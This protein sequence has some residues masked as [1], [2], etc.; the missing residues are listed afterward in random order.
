MAVA[1]VVLGYFYIQ[2]RG[3]IKQ[4]QDIAAHKQDTAKIW[5]DAYDHEHATL[6]QEQESYGVAMIFHKKEMDSLASL[7]HT[8]ASKLNSVTTAHDRISF[9]VTPGNVKRFYY[10]MPDTSTHNAGLPG[11]KPV[12]FPGQI[13]RLEGTFDDY[14]LHAKVM[15]GDTN[16][17][18]AHIDDTTGIVQYTKGFF[19]A[20]PYIDITHRAKYVHTNSVTSYAIREPQG[21]FEVVIFA[22]G[23][24]NVSN[25]DLKRPQAIFGIGIAKKL[26][27]FGKK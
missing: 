18:Q 19:N 22:G 10:T 7:Y 21:G 23:G 24:Y 17:I 16:R 12:I 27:S 14:W 6:Q 15:L 4:A 13:R 3:Q 20:K 1:I 25:L 26:F 11:N 8:S 2:S 9:D 5:K